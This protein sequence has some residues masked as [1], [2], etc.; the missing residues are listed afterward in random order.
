MQLDTRYVERLEK[1]IVDKD[2]VISMLRGELAHTNEEIVRRN[3]RER[4]T[5]IL[6]R[7]LQNLVLR[8]QA[9]K[10]PTANVLDGEV[11]RDREITDGSPA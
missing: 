3:E 1:R 7:G 4:E 8:L 10:R 9:G 11:M 6:I 2:E 5:K